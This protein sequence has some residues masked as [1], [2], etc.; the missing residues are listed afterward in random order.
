[1][2]IRRDTSR[3]CIVATIY[4]RPCPRNLIL[5]QIHAIIKHEILSRLNFE[6]TG[7]DSPGARRGFLGNQEGEEIECVEKTTVFH[8]A[9]LTSILIEIQECSCY[10]ITRTGN[11]NIQMSIIFHPS[12]VAY[13]FFQQ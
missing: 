11:T 5:L 9:R 2:L 4:R 1:M 12:P 8:T 3:S 6:L 7:F 13:H 10:S